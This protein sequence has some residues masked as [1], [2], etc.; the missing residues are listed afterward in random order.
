MKRWEY[1]EHT[2]SPGYLVHQLNRF[3]AV[4]WE[5]MRMERSNDDWYILFRREVNSED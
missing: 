4:G 5:V 2:C 1:A 3:G